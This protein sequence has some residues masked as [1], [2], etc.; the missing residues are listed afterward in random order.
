MG[1]GGRVRAAHLSHFCPGGFGFPVTS[2]NAVGLDLED[3]HFL[4]QS[5]HLVADHAARAAGQTCARCAD[6]IAADQ[7]ARRRGGGDWVH[8]SC[9]PP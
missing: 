6:A 8:E 9:P 1:I 3:A 5:W 7:H 2:P 4:R